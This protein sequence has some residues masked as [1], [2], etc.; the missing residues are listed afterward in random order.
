MKKVLV[1]I[2]ILL[3]CLNQR[4]YYHAA[5]GLID[6]CEAGTLDGFLGA[7]EITTLS[8]FLNKSYKDKTQVKE[9]LT[10]ILD[11]FSVVPADE[12]ILRA[13]L[14]SNITD[15]EDAVLACSAEK[16][17]AAYIITRNISDFKNSPIPAVT[18]EIF[19]EGM[20]LE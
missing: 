12:S 2:N 10:A 13:A 4:N 14:A 11:I 20:G 15:F 9:I 18:P 1:D 6:A 8:Y 7:H 19:L 3:D 5:A 17:P 16:V